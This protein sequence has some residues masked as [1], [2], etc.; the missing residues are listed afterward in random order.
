MYPR[1][2]LS[3]NAQSS[4]VEDVWQKAKNLS[5]DEKSELIERL[6]D[7]ESDLIVVSA[8][9]PLA[10]HVIA[11]TNL[12]SLEGLTYVWESIIGRIFEES[13]NSRC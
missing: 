6:L 2:L 12:L 9:T 13:N 4:K 3:M 8:T 7:K 11:L 10:D 5:L 1:E